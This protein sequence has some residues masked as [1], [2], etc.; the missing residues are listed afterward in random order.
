MLFHLC[1]YISSLFLARWKMTLSWRQK[2][3]PLPL[4]W[5]LSIFVASLYFDSI[6]LCLP[7]TPPKLQCLWGSSFLA[8]LL[9]SHYIYQ[10][11]TLDLN[12][13]FTFYPVVA[14][15]FHNFRD[16]LVRQMSSGRQNDIVCPT[17]ASYYQQRNIFHIHSAVTPVSLIQIQN[18][19]GY[20]IKKISVLWTIE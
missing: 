9:A 17:P 20:Q 19:C 13:D 15:L 14:R 5:I 2:K 10:G 11:S 4:S 6:F 8:N 16:I 3:K 7:V 18:I 1:N 12:Q